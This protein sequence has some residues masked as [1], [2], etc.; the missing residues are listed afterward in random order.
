MNCLFLQI[1]NRAFYF[2]FALSLAVNGSLFAQPTC[3]SITSGNWTDASTWS[4]GVVP[5][6]PPYNN[7]VIAA[8]DT[9]LIQNGESIVFTDSTNIEVFGFLFIGTPPPPAGFAELR[10]EN[11]SSLLQ[12]YT[13]GQINGAN[14]GQI[15]VGAP[16]GFTLVAG[17][18]VGAGLDGP[19]SITKDS[20]D[21]PLPVELVYFRGGRNPQ[22]VLLRWQTATELNNDYF[23]IELSSDGENF[24]TIAQ[25]AGN[26]TT[27]Q[28]NNYE[29]LHGSPL[30]GLNYYRLKQVDYNG[31]F[32]YFQTVVVQN[33]TAVPLFCSVYPNPADAVIKLNLASSDN[34]NALD[35][36]LYDTNGRIVYKLPI[37]AQEREIELK[38]SE[39][40]N[41]L[42]YFNVQQAREF[43]HGKMLIQ[44]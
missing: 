21:A 31:D 43:F 16:P 37:D 27:S 36:Y 29:W 14:N 30:V 35:L 22:G 15:V 8:T 26:G 18:E 9:V 25:M 6:N 11:D 41:G 12:I 3:T 4:C 28:V 33:D 40:N 32:E 44:H 1:M 24:T 38:T 42:Y 34:E 19:R 13:G 20:S 39:L 17:P 10:L 2:L 23:E 5:M 7:I